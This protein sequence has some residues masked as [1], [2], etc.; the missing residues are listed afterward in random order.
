MAGAT[1]FDMNDKRSADKKKALD[2]ALAQIERQFGKGAIMKLGDNLQLVED[3]KPAPK[4]KA[5][6][7]TDDLV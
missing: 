3:E 6:A 4:G 2:S 5:K 7:A 1:L